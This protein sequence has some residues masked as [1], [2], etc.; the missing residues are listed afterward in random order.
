MK[1]ETTRVKVLV[2]FEGGN[3]YEDNFTHTSSFDMPVK[4]M[5]S[6]L[7]EIAQDLKENH[8]EHFFYNYELSDVDFSIDDDDELA[9]EKAWEDYLFNCWV[10]YEILEE[11]EYLYIEEV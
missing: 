7:D 6:Y 9:E 1:R 11:E 3:G 5:T 10:G 4:E 2:K 8:A